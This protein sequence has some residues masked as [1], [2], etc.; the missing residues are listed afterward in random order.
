MRLLYIVNLFS[1]GLGHGVQGTAVLE[2][3]NLASVEG[4]GQLDVERLAILGLDNEGDGLAGFELG[5][6]NVNLFQSC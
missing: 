6:L 4:V 2:P 5:A 1:V 3:L